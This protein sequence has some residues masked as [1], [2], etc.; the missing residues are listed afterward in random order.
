MAKVRSSQLIQKALKVPSGPRAKTIK[1]LEGNVALGPR[2]TKA[3][4]KGPR[5]R[6]KGQ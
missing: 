6:M 5:L 1:G 2:G 3:L 4:M